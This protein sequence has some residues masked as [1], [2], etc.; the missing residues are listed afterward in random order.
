MGEGK[1][2]ENFNKKNEFLQKR[3]HFIKINTFVKDYNL[4]LMK[5]C[6]LLLFS[7]FFLF[8]YV[9]GQFT[10]EI[11]FSPQN[12]SVKEYNFKVTKNAPDSIK[13]PFS[14]IRIID[15]R[16]DTSK[17]GFIYS[18]AFI[19]DGM[20]A[21]KKL[22]FKH[23]LTKSIEDYCSRYYNNS[24][25]NTGFDLL[26]IIK[27]FWLSGIEF[28]K[29]GSLKITENID[30]GTT[31]HVKWEFYIGKD[32]Q[33]LAFK[34]IDTI[35]KNSFG[36]QLKNLPGKDDIIFKFADFGSVINSLIEKYNFSKAIAVFND[37][38]NKTLSQISDYN[39]QR[40]SLPIL[41]DSASPDGIF[42]SFEEFV[43]NKPKIIHFKEK[44]TK[45]SNFKKEE[46]LTSLKDS[47][48][49]GYWGYSK[50]N[51]LKIGQFGNDKL[52]RKGN[53][54]EFFKKITFEKRHDISVRRG[55]FTYKTENEIWVPYQIDM[56]TG[57][58][59]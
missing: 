23:G 18:R 3:M 56:E 44:T 6:L 20:H 50:D 24:F 40:F 51:I 4:A 35:L 49:T 54:F 21:F 26:I 46:Y 5:P 27:K 48:I 1:I 19:K 29:T 15:S 25:Q 8:P 38:E 13:L 47:L 59:Y 17:I 9:N 36:N 37:R 55:N 53:T 2:G 39:Q 58:I 32:K 33:Y 11:G 14:S 43:A 12:L 7:F 34:R 16:F 57:N 31:L 41:R 45:Y 22:Q 42:Y 28:S 10:R 52:F 30:A